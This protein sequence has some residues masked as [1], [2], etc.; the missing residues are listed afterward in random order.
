MAHGESRTL[1]KDSTITQLANIGER[2]A[3]H[4]PQNDAMRR[5]ST[6]QEGPEELRRTWNNG[7]ESPIREEPKRG[8]SKTG[9]VGGTGEEETGRQEATGMEWVEEG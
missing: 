1:N 4:G 2:N 6:D 5:V 9:I 3:Q 7:K 8:K